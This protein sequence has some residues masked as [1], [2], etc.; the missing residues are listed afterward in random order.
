MLGLLQS[1]FRAFL[2]SLVFLPQPG[3]HLLVPGG[4]GG[5]RLTL[6]HGSRERIRELRAQGHGRAVNLLETLGEDPRLLRR[7]LARVGRAAVS[8][9]ERRRRRRDGLFESALREANLLS[10]LTAALPQLS[11]RLRR[12]RDGACPDSFALG[13]LLGPDGLPDPPPV[14]RAAEDVLHGAGNFGQTLIDGQLWIDAILPDGF[15]PRGFRRRYGHRSLRGSLPFAPASVGVLGMDP[16]CLQVGGAIRRGGV[17]HT[18]NGGSQ[19]RDHV[20][21]LGVPAPHLVPEA[22]RLPR[23]GNELVLRAFELKLDRGGLLSRS[24]ER[25]LHGR[26][27]RGADAV[28]QTF[29]LLDALLGYALNLLLLGESIPERTLRLRR[30]FHHGGE[31]GA[32]GFASVLPLANLLLERGGFLLLSLQRGFPSLGHLH[33]LLV[34]G[35]RHLRAHARVVRDGRA[36]GASLHHPRRVDVHHGDAGSHAR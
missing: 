10:H 17:A 24:L 26:A 34:R 6:L 32:E 16:E 11:G 2:V 21:V 30:L 7:A 1:L 33:Q 12:V 36:V 5:G 31:L 3:G 35:A 28:E 14:I 27:A 20:R 13:I 4:G 15:N 25:C 9:L 18:P 29:E 19:R 8:R 22:L 23:R